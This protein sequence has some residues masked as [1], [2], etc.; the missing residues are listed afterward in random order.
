[1]YIRYVYRTYIYIYKY[2]CLFEQGR[3]T[4]ILNAL[5]FIRWCIGRAPKASREAYRSKRLQAWNLSDLSDLQLDLQEIFPAVLPRIFLK[6]R[7]WKWNLLQRS[8]ASWGCCKLQCSMDSQSRA[9]LNRNIIS[10]KSFIR[11]V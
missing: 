7:R 11:V 10:H 5:F 3:S 4:L 9:V 1:M 6:K 8:A 2:T